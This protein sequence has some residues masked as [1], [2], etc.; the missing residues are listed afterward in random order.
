ML[1]L[2]TSQEEGYVKLG[3]TFSH[4]YRYHITNSCLRNY[5]ALSCVVCSSKKL[6]H[7]SALFD[8][9]LKLFPAVLYFY[10]HSKV[11]LCRDDRFIGNV[12]KGRQVSILHS[13]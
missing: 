11:M 1:S 3:I 10:C 9:K 12:A 8:I 2:I 7:L 4:N 13:F 5:S 6:F